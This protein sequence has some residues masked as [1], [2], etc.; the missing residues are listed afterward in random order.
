MAARRT[1]RPPRRRE[2]PGGAGPSSDASPPAAG[3]APGRP[4]PWPCDDPEVAV[5]AV[6]YRGAPCDSAVGETRGVDRGQPERPAGGWTGLDAAR[7][8][9]HRDRRGELAGTAA[10]E[11]LLP[12]AR[13]RPLA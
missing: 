2:G 3:A 5:D 11:A 13:L 10:G 9:Q 6:T 12:A 4:L 1:R 7:R 8:E